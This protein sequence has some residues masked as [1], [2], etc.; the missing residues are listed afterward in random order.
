MKRSI[1]FWLYF[2]IAIILA[3]YICARVTMTAMG[4]GNISLVRGIS[5][6][7]DSKNH[8]LTQ[9]ATA[10]AV[11][12]G[13]RMFSVDLD[14]INH[15]IQNVPGVRTSAVRRRPN[16]KLIVRVNMYQ[17]VAQWSDGTAYFPLSAD[18]T[19]V[20]R[21]SP[22]RDGGAVVFRGELP[23]DITDIT[24]AAHTMGAH[25]D[26]L[27]WIEGRRWNLHTTG[28]ITVM[29]PEIDPESAI[30]GLMI[31]EKNHHILAKNITE[32][33]MRDTA[34]ILITK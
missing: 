29:L 20:K 10:A 11:A 5:I 12:P 17:A 9:I 31:L 18:G 27:E 15:R 24:K 28:G 2:V 19:I 26:Y 33:D 22:E 16:G 4:H 13:T 7:A 1:W 25:L 34:R 3:V 30:A 8:D 6:S 23:N 14:T 21:P 32:I